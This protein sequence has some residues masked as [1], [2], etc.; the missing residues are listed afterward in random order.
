LL[1]FAPDGRTLL[2]MGSGPDG[3]AI[4]HWD[5]ATQTLLKRVAAYGRLLSPD[6]RLAVAVSQTET[7]A[8]RADM[9]SAQ[10]VANVL[11]SGEKA[12]G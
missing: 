11:P 5:L 4:C 6:G 12:M 7:V 10:V 8:L 3:N 2:S 1:V 9:D